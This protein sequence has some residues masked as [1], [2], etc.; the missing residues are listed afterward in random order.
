MKKLYFLFTLLLSMIGATNALAEEI[1]VEINSRTG[2]WTAGTSV[3]WAKEWATVSEDP[4][5]TIKNLTGENNMAYWDKVN[6]QF[7]NSQAYSGTSKTYEF[8]VSAGY[9]ITGISLDFVKYARPADVNGAH[10]VTGIVGISFD[11]VNV[12]EN[13]SYE[14]FVHAEI[15]GIE[16][17]AVGM[18]VSGANPGVFA[19][20][21]DIV[22][23]LEKQGEEDAAITELSAIVEEYEAY[24]YNF[25]P[26]DEPGNYNA[27]AVAAF[28]QALDDAHEAVDGGDPDADP[29]TADDYRKLGQDIKDTYEAVLAS[30]NTTYVLAD[31]YYRIKTAAKY[32]TTESVIDE[33]TGEETVN[34]IYKDKYMYSVLEGTTIYGRWGTPEDIS[35]DCPTLWKIE[36]KEEGLDILNMATDARFNNI[37]RSANATM[38]INGENLMAIEPVITLDGITSANI[39]VATQDGANGVYLHQGG[40]GMSAST[41]YEGTG[42]GAY[43]VGWY[44]TLSAANEEFHPGGSEWQFIPVT[45]EEAQAII[46]AYKPIKDETLMRERYKMM[47][48]DA[49]TKI[50]IARDI[51]SDV[52]DFA[53]IVDETQFS[54]PFSDSEEG[55]NFAALLDGQNST[56]WHSDWHHGSQ[57]NGTH[58][59][60]VEITDADVDAIALTFTRRPVTNDHITEWA[61]YGTNNSYE[62][63][64]T[65]DKATCEPL[66]TLSTPYGN[67]T[68]TITTK[69]FETKG[70]KSLLFYIN[71]TTTS[72]GYGHVS[73]FQLYKAQ[74][75]DSPTTQYKVMGDIAKNLDDVLTAQANINI[76]EL[77]VE[78][79]NTMKEAYD[80]FIEKFVDPTE[81]RE[82]LA[83]VQGASDGIV[84]GSNPGYWSDNSTA[85]TLANTVEA[86]KAYDV[87]GSFTQEQS[88]TY[89]ADLTA[90][91]EAIMEAA[92]KIQ[93]GKWYRIR[94]ASEQDFDNHGWDKIAG[95]NES[96]NFEPLWDKYLAVCN[97]V[98]SEDNPAG[99]E[100]EA[101]N[102]ED[103]TIGENIFFDDDEDIE[104]KDMSLFRFV[105]VGDSAYYLQNKATN[106][107]LKAAGTSGFVTLSVHP[108]L[109]N[110]KAIGYGFNIIAAKAIDGANQNYLHAQKQYNI[111]VTWNA[112]TVGSASGMYIEEVEDVAS[113]YTGEEFNV[114]ALEGEISTF[115]FPVEVES[116]DGGMYGVQVEGT[117][118]K[119]FPMEKAE[120]GRPFIYI[121]GETENYNEENEREMVVF[122]HGYDFVKE[123]GTSEALKGTFSSVVLDR[124]EA[125]ASGNT[126]VVNTIRKDTPIVDERVSVGANKA[127]ISSE[128]GFAL[129]AELTIEID[130]SIEDGIAETLN[131][132]AK[133]GEIYAIDGR[134][135]SNKGNVNDLRRFGKG[136]Y[137]LNGVKVV[138]K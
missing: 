31:G 118:I 58:Y 104:E 137:I 119:L 89:V 79:Y 33:E 117:T 92:N 98:A 15:T 85:T 54:S 132:V 41:N 70:Y 87:A 114:S 17:S 65:I 47:V 50:E 133:S 138:V 125:Y 26:G 128:E 37:S 78:Q 24:K 48:A 62:P 25:N 94:F 95:Y 116:E 32:R 63:T 81:L 91:A 103:A 129:D 72:R 59:L 18:I 8:R 5:I 108:S 39:R 4:R 77:T 30:R 36:N 22:V 127:Y 60:K 38:S 97:Y 99:Y 29:L 45:E 115:C 73:E 106:L 84:L 111:L 75:I 40:H 44:S 56:Y 107:F 80:A 68:E 76:D 53:L 120:A 23:T 82:T 67:N 90:Q 57:P 28:Q 130:G 1:T 16:E 13:E 11:G 19:N 74:I 124:G 43:L 27:E 100:I 69:A 6:I 83:N 35:T 51:K 126:F 112:Y 49:T 9:L 110:V 55:T 86:A 136:I 109:F 105:A 42:N 2:E 122:K 71:A 20:T 7:Y 135:V 96:Q 101:L 14:E 113:D 46:E 61:V 131:K 93:T 34:T 102:A 121:L 66:A 12:F 52:S 123:P 10:D 134:L 88:D 3:S 64:D 21:K